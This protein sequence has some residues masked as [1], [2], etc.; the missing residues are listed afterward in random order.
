VP[1]RREAFASALGLEG[2]EGWKRLEER[3]RTYV[4]EVLLPR[5]GG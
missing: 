2:P 3:F 4:V 1:D 5:E